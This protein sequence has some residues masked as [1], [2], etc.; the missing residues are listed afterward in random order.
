MVSWTC[1]LLGLW[2]EL[3]FAESVWYFDKRTETYESTACDRIVC[4]N[5]MYE[6]FFH[7]LGVGYEALYRVRVLCE[8][9]HACKRCVFLNISY[10]PRKRGRIPRFLRTKFVRERKFSVAKRIRVTIRGKL[11]VLYERGTEIHNFLALIAGKCAISKVS[12]SVFNIC[13]LKERT[14]CDREPVVQNFTVSRVGFS[15]TRCTDPEGVY[16]RRT[17]AWQVAR[18]TQSSLQLPNCKSWKRARYVWFIQYRV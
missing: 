7:P 15:Y 16:S 9:S 10:V 11:T 3:S 17:A 2:Q 4:V 18:G 1:K 12:L 5:M 6:E 14:C 8:F 13:T